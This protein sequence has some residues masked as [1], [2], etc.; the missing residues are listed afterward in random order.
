[1]KLREKLLENIKEGKVLKTDQHWTGTRSSK[2]PSFICT[3][4][5]FK[6]N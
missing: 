1:M 6:F 5:R 4:N 3:I 2:P